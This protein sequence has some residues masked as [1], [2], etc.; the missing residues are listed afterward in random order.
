MH[1]DPNGN[2]EAHPAG[3]DAQP[4]LPT[5][6]PSGRPLPSPA[7]V[8]P[9]V[10]THEDVL[11]LIGE[12]ERQMER[13]RTAQVRSSE[14][15]AQFADRARRLDEREHQ[16]HNAEALLA[17]REAELRAMS[18]AL[19]EET[20][21]LGERASETAAREERLSSGERAAEER[22]DALR[23][24][25]NALSEREELVERNRESM[26][27]ERAAMCAEREAMA[28]ERESMHAA[29]EET[30]REAQ[31]AAAERDALRVEIVSVHERI[32]AL[33][34]QVEE[35]TRE[36]A[37]MS[38]AFAKEAAAAKVSAESLQA[39]E[40]NEATLMLT[41]ASLREMNED[42]DASLASRDQVVEA[43][44]RVIAERDGQIIELQR[45][46]DMTRQSL[47]TAGDKLAALAKSVADQAPQLE[48]GAAA[49]G[50][51]TEQRQ[52]IADDEARIAS[53]EREL[54]AA[55]E[56]ARTAASAVPEKVVERV[57]ETVVETVVDTAA[58]DEAKSEIDRLREEIGRSQREASEARQALHSDGAA[59]A[60]QER[61]LADTQSRLQEA[62]GFLAQRKRR[63]DLARRLLRE[64]RVKRE[65]E[66]RQATENAMVRV[67]EEERLVKK[68]RE[69]LRQVQELLTSSERD[70]VS[71]YAR[72]RGALVAAWIMIVVTSLA[73]G[74]WF[75]APMVLPGNAI[76]SVD[77][78][79]KL[80]EGEPL[81]PEQDVLF[82]RVHTD[83]LQDEGLRATVKKRMSER[84]INALKNNAE[85]E[86]WLGDVQVDSDGL[87]TLRLIAPAPDPTT[88]TLA[89]DT[90][91]TTL[92]NE[93]PKLGKG[94]GDV[95]RIGIAGNT[96]VPGRLS[97]STLVPQAGPWD[98]LLAAGM[99]FSAVFTLG[100][101]VGIV[102]F[103]KIA[104]TKRRFEDAERFGATL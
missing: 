81:T 89:L 3:H 40:R 87:G 71:R 66:I 76:A 90:L 102:V 58:L 92:A 5:H 91:A 4:T 59:A 20:L 51:V 17:A 16:L 103:G 57:V 52:R 41:V 84:G 70:M 93:S 33:D 72:H 99:I 36:R 14:E 64:R 24:R 65:L 26:E 13:L 34:R 82:Q 28:A 98:R 104:R 60:E 30:K 38:E 68:Q 75:A 80:K 77:L 12:V 88:A 44:D 63:I 19:H 2:V 31:S 43:K 79:A 56:S 7:D 37:L 22:Q 27:A 54:A 53:L 95:P 100:L 9:P 96:Q 35:F 50:L 23:A 61:A 15:F 6:D 85:F 83:A 94:K 48:R 69:E 45:E 8:V 21:R 47:R 74:A 73:A 11:G 1:G 67:L 29:A 42:A 101:V 32:V 49:L 18:D 25:D 86:A 39:A 55:L 62:L 46:V 78:V 97:Y 10:R